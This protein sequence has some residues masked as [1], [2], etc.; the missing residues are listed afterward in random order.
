MDISNTSIKN[1]LI[2]VLGFGILLLLFHFFVTPEH[3][4]ML[5]DATFVE[6]LITCLIAYFIF[7][8]SGVLF[9]YLFYKSTQKRFHFADILTFP[10]ARGLWGFLIPFQGSIAYTLFFCKAKYK[11]AIRQ[12]LSVNIYLLLFN[13]MLTGVVGIWCATIQG[14]FVSLL[15]VISLVFLLNP[16]LLYFAKIAL[17]SFSLKT[18]Q[19][20]ICYIINTLRSIFD[21]IYLLWKDR[22]NFFIIFGIN[23]AHIGITVGWYFWMSKILDFNLSYIAILMLT[24]IQRISFILKFTPG[25]LGVNQ[26]FSGLAF[27]LVKE[28]IAKGII[29]SAF[30]SAIVIL[31]VFSFGSFVTL[32]NL[33]YFPKKKIGDIYNTLT[34]FTINSK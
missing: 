19:K 9:A 3:F 26:L 12:T 6:I 4:T 25:N 27:H 14:N 28:D 1:I 22:K 17:D 10:A 16:F 31:L 5:K 23:I 15:F 21:R 33:K 30:G 34:T 18:E 24:M 8:L 29:L 7:C 20:Y 32:Y 11:V 2:Y 13:I